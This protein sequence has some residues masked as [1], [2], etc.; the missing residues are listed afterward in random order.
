MNSWQKWKGRIKKNVVCDEFP[1]KKECDGWWI[2]NT[3]KGKKASKAAQRLN[4]M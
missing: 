1:T 3:K 4:D 2:T